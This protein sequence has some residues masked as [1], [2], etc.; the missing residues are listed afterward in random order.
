MTSATVLTVRALQASP[1]VGAIV[2]DRI[3]PEW[4]PSSEFP[5]I[6]VHQATGRQHYGAGGPLPVRYATL[7]ILCAAASYPEADRLADTVIS[8]LKGLRHAGA[9]DERI[10]LL[11]DGADTG[12]K[13]P[14][15]EAFLRIIGYRA[16][17]TG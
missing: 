7:N 12:T 10:T 3:E 8:A 1:A 5:R 6:V 11:Q 4:T 14:D 15:S 9:G 2:G 17:I 13:D 16:T